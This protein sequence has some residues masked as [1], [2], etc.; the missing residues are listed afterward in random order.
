[1]PDPVWQTRTVIP[2]FRAGFTSQANAH[3]ET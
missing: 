1:M 2:H 3:V